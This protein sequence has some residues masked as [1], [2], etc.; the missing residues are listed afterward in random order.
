MNRLIDADFRLSLKKGPNIRGRLWLLVVLAAINVFLC[1]A[2]N[3]T[4]RDPELAYFAITIPPSIL[5]SCFVTEYF[6]VVGLLETEFYRVNNML[7]SCKE[8]HYPSSAIS[9]LRCESEI[10]DLSNHSQLVALRSLRSIHTMLYE[11]SND[12]ANFFSFPILLCICHCFVTL[13]YCVYWTII[14]LLGSN[15]VFLLAHTCKEFHFTLVI[16]Y[17]V[18]LLVHKVTR[19]SDEAKQTGLKVHKLMVTTAIPEIKAEVTRIISFRNY[20]FSFQLEEFSLRILHEE[21]NFTACGF[22]RLDFTLL[23]SMLATLVTYLVILIQYTGRS[24]IDEKDEMGYTYGVLHS[25]ADP[26]LTLILTPSDGSRDF[27]CFFMFSKDHS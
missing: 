5:I 16:L 18:T 13:V 4:Y 14:P 19:T 1:I 7:L 27:S 21:L 24:K 15:R 22:F 8:F 12:V 25:K 9:S 3:V 6:L 26:R 17:P 2:L 23:Q 20:K 10:S 11:I